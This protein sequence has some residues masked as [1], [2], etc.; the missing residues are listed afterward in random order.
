MP[1]LFTAIELPDEVRHRLAALKVPLPG[2]R[3]LEPGNLHLT[4][5]FAGDIDNRIARDFADG[6]A[7]IDCDPFE[8]RLNGL[9]TFGGNDPRAIW[10]GVEAGPQL[11]TLARA[12]ERAARGAGLAPEGRN[13]KP[14]VTLARLS[15]PR[16]EAV[17]K[18]LQRHGAFR[19]EP[20]LVTRF[21]LMSSRPQT[22]GGPYVVEDA[23]P[24][25]GFPAEPYEHDSWQ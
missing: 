15:H 1:R 24:M 8:L 7:A 5:R 22:G 4:L 12:N 21:V 9:G 19:T 2:A 10:A 6:L 20:F 17:A 11:E 14:H 3:W 25:G 18:F 13:F 23:F 16:I